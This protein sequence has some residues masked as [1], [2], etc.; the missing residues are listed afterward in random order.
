M[1]FRKEKL[2]ELIRRLVS[3]VL[4]K[5]INDPR[6][7]F[8]TITQVTLN[9]DLSIAQVGVSMLGDSRDIRKGYDGLL[10]ARGFIQKYVGNNLHIRNVPRIEFK[11][12][13]SV[14][15]SVRMVD[16]LENLDGVKEAKNKE[17]DSETG[18]E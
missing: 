11:L 12:D 7:G 15:E 6:I 13:S 8:V 17:E 10:S 1:A 3:E 18:S 9:K 2:E 5:E 16:F 4:I 14:S